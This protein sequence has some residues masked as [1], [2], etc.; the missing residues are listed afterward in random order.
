MLDHGCGICLRGGVLEAL[1]VFIPTHVLTQSA[2]H[3][4]SD[5]IAAREVSRPARQTI[6]D[7]RVQ[8][9]EVN[10]PW[11]RAGGS[12]APLQINTVALG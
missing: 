9:H 6:P 2:L 12:A 5:A 10:S 7:K 4:L 11:Q 3:V 1:D 8:E